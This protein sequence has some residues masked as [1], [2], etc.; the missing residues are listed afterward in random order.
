ML[1]YVVRAFCSAACLYTQHNAEGSERVLQKLKNSVL[2]KMLQVH[3]TK[4]EVDVILE[5]SHY[6]DDAGRIYGVYY[7]DVCEAI[8]ISY[9]TFY[10][11]IRSL[12]DKELIR[13]QKDFRGDWDII[14]IGNDFSYPEALKEGYISTGHDI[15]YN[16]AFKKLKANEK[17][18]A[19]QFIKIGGAGK[20][21]H[22]GVNLLYEK[23]AALLQVTKR[24]IQVYLGRLREFF[25]IGIKDKMYWITPLKSVFKYNAPTDSYSYAEHL[26]KTACR[27]NKVICSEQRKKD[28]LQLIRQYMGELLDRTSQVFLHAVSGSLEKGNKNISDKRKWN[29]EINPKFVHK[30]IRNEL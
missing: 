8:G 7:K 3:L 17:L 22:I 25:S 19:M 2:D 15:F 26:V 14:I 5:I 10:V 23:Y 27:R 13:L 28:M 1:S 18:L 29:R 21:Y 11:T 12:S 30:L 9:E 20:H 4:A 24:T 16:K 6:Q